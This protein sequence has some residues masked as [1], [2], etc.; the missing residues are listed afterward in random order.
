MS[1]EQALFPMGPP[2]LSTPR[3]EGVLELSWLQWAILIGSV[4]VFV[5]VVGLIVVRIVRQRRQ[6]LLHSADERLLREAGASAELTAALGQ[7]GR[8][9]ALG[10]ISELEYTSRRAALLAELKSD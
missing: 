7:L 5:L 9:R 4:V 6:P 2:M 1:R 3:A 8:E 10:R